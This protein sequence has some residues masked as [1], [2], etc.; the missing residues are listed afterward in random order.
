M[1]ASDLSD[2]E[3]LE[4]VAKRNITIFGLTKQEIL[5]L[6]KVYLNAKGKLPVTVSKIREVFKRG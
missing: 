1:R 4:E 5:E 2:A 3:I 6:R